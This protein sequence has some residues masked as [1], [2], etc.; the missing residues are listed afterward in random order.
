GRLQMAQD[1]M[2]IL[3]TDV[4]AHLSIDRESHQFVLSLNVEKPLSPVWVRLV[5]KPITLSSIQ[6]FDFKNS[7]EKQQDGQLQLNFSFGQ[8]S[9]GTLKLY[10]SKELQSK[11]NKREFSI[12]LP[13]YPSPIGQG[14]PPE[15]RGRRKK[16]SKELYP[17]E[18]YEKL[19]KDTEKEIK[20]PPQT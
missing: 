8:M 3:D 19:Y 16:D 20:T 10:D 2:L 9:E 1:L 13:G 4:Q 12:Y 7:D 6:S 15:E 17:T 5:E 11:E 18:V 14:E